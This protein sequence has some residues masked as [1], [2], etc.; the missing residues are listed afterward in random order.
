MLNLFVTWKLYETYLWFSSSYAIEFRTSRFSKKVVFKFHVGK[1]KFQHFPPWKNPLLHLEK[2]TIDPS[3]DQIL[4]TP[5]AW[6]KLKIYERRVRCSIG[7]CHISKPTRTS[8]LPPFW[9]P[10]SCLFRVS[11]GVFWL[12]FFLNH[13]SFRKEISKAYELYKT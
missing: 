8:P 13:H 4:P 1:M 5:M 6:H 7:K 11:Y 12:S 3:L 9:L 2:S 10:W